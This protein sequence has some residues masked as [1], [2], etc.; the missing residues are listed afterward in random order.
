MIRIGIA[1]C[2]Y[3][4]PNLVR[5]FSRTPGCR[6][7]SVCDIAED[8]L[9]ALVQMYPWISFTTST[10]QFL[11]DTRLDA[12]VIATPVATH[13][14]LAMKALRSGRHV[15]IEK[16]MVADSQSALRLID[17]A[18]RRSLTLMVDYP[19]VFGTPVRKIA[20][21]ISAGE[22]GDFYYYDS[23]RINL[24]RF[25]SDVNVLWDLAA[26]DLSILDYLTHQCPSAVSATGA[27][28]A[29]AGFHTMAYLTMFYDDGLLGHVHVNW[30]APLK[31]RRTL[32]GG[33]QQMIV[34]DEL[35]PSEKVRVYDRGVWQSSL[36]H[37]DHAS[38]QMAIG[39]RSGDMWAPHL[40]VR[41]A[42][43]TAATQFV[44]CVVAKARPLTDGQ[45]GLRV[46]RLLE[47]ATESLMASGRPIHTKAEVC[48]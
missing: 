10:D 7:L 43:E 26:H 3:W 11:A 32:I 12:I 2:G 48:S 18:E 47:A 5:A 14:E 37:T 13:A 34:Y 38:R 29:K 24:G 31:I 27:K 17:E 46:V 20:D 16:P 28:H 6:V 9:T 25:Q 15:F 4:G 42:L 39:Y 19:F 21:L 41:D 44:E 8:R 22:I 30:L 23:V 40:E 36:G 35:E 45:S 33:S 1:G